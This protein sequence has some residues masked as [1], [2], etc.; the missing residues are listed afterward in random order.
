MPEGFLYLAFLRKVRYTIYAGFILSSVPRYRLI[1]G[2]FNT[3]FLV[4][5]YKSICETNKRIAT[6][7]YG[8]LRTVTER[9]E[10]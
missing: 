7:R 3:N 4:Q 10:A 6:E 1:P 5:S 9:N 2:I 8:A